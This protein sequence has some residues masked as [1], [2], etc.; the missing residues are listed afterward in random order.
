MISVS[1]NG[2][3]RDGID[4]G[5]IGSTIQGL[6]REGMDVCVT[7]HAKGAGIDARV[8]AGTCPPGPYSPRRAT[9][10]EDRI[11]ALWRSCGVTG[12]PAPG[13]LIQCLKRLEREL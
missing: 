13:R 6:R 7:V 5:W 3:Q 2:M 1:I 12:D 4:E 10:E 11:F 9:A 8:V